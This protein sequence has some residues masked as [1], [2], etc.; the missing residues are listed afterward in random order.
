MAN[1][2]PIQNVQNLTSAEQLSFN[3]Y[4]NS[5]IISP[6]GVDQMLSIHQPMLSDMEKQQMIDEVMNIPGIKTWSDNWKF[7]TM[8]FLGTYGPIN[9]WQYAVIHLQLLPSDDAISHC[10]FG[11]EAYAKVDL[12]TKKIVSAV[13]PTKDGN[14]ECKFA[15]GV[16]ASNIKPV[17]NWYALPSAYATT[18]PPYQSYAIVGQYDVT[19]SNWYGN[20]ADL[21][22]PYYNLNIFS[23][24]NPNSLIEQLLNANW[25]QA[26]GFTQAGWVILNFNTPIGISANTE[27]LVYVDESTY[28]NDNLHNT[29]INVLSGYNETVTIT[30]N[31][32][33][34]KQQITVQY[35]YNNQMFHH[36]TTV[37]CSTY[38]SSD[39]GNNS[40]FLENYN[41]GPSA[42]W[43]KDIVVNPIT[44]TNAKEYDSSQLMYSWSGYVRF[45]SHAQYV[46]PAIDDYASLVVTGGLS[47]GGTA[48]WSNLNFMA[49]YAQPCGPYT[50]WSV[51]VSCIIANNPTTLSGDTTIK[52][53]AVLVVP[54]I[55]VLTVPFTSNKLNIE[56]SGTL[57]VEPHG[58]VKSPLMSITNKKLCRIIK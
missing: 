19:T 31:T 15:G 49:P 16:R 12:A 45:D 13:Y 26:N 30:C 25:N 38:Q 42:N 54:S 20:K 34:S 35:S 29:G 37:P 39:Y 28:F 18:Y 23:D 4:S 40:V 22:P 17:S 21:V 8:D 50:G 33:T 7:V 58:I 1:A 48:T 14:Y 2:S 44:A 43:S 5:T 55:N 36:D 46:N 41:D 56:P 32:S 52:N 6:P 51:S 47:S 53:G 10:D 57:L 9:S 27:D 11:W 3:G 24:M